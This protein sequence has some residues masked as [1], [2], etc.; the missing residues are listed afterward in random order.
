MSYK[1]SSRKKK[2]R[3][4]KNKKK[5]R[6]Q[7]G[8]A[9]TP[10]RQDPQRQLSQ[11]I[12]NGNVQVVRASIAAGADVNNNNDD[13]TTPLT[14]AS[15]EGHLEVVRALLEAGADVNKSD[16]TKYN[17]RSRLVGKELKR[18]TKE[19][20]LAHELFSPMPPWEMIKVLLGFMVTEGF[21]GSTLMT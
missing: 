4:K 8:S 7:R 16:T 2:Y 6:R 12:W 11:A 3:D 10:T 21:D 19:Q 20:L 15:S 5:T 1:I 14:L 17:I 13:R 18:K 9:D